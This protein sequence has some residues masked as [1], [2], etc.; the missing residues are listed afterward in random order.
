VFVFFGLVAVLGAYFVQ[1]GSI[2]PA[3][4]VAAAAIGLHAAAVLLVNNYRDRDHDAATGRSTLATVISRPAAL[5]LYALL[6][7][8]PFALALGI[9]WMADSRWYALPLIALPRAIG[10]ARALPGAPPGA[11]QSAL[12]FRTVLLEVAFGLLLSLAAVLHRIAP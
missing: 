6:L 10:L 7:T 4:W 8:V 2:V 1:T 3:A 5:R 9:A 11:A 12:L